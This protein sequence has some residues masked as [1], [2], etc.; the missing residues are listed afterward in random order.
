M[1]SSPSHFNQELI[2]LHCLHV[3]YSFLVF[4]LYFS[5]VLCLYLVSL[6]AKGLAKDWLR[7]S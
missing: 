7:E 2:F 3:F 6:F 1:T 4:L 5:C